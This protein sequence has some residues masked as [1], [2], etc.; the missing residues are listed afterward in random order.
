MKINGVIIRQKS[1]LYTVFANNQS[2]NCSARGKFRHTNI[3]P[4]VG[5][6][7]TITTEDNCIIDI[8]DRKNKLDRPPIANIDIALIITSVKEPN[9][10]LN[11]LDRQLVCILSQN[12]KPIIVLSKID[13][14]S[15]NE[16]K[17]IKKIC[18]YYQKIGIKVIQNNKLSKLKRLL[19]G[20]TVVL[21]GQTG[22]GKSTLLNKLDKNLNIETNE[23]SK[24]LGRGVHTTRHTEIYN[25]DGIF[26]ADTPGFSSLDINISKDKLKDY[27]P[28]FD[29]KCTFKD[30]MHIKE[31]NCIVKNLVK[32]GKIMKSR[33]DNY[34]KFWS[35]L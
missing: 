12:I 8:L 34:V 3:T 35:E 20:K 29:V 21:T 14:L 26:I 25:I 16:K 19:K 2:F 32:S 23:I 13:L 4:L 1:N 27:Y 10:S 17:D 30:C 7:C 9:L 11:L 6:Y 31:R 5:D 15:S 22:A 33:Y 24:A 28:E 18:K